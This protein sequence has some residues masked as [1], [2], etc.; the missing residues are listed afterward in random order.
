MGSLLFN[1]TSSTPYPLRLVLN[2]ILPGCNLQIRKVALCSRSNP[3]CDAAFP[4]FQLQIV[5]DE[6]G[7][8]RSMHV[9]PG[10]TAFHLD[11]EPGP[12]AGL[13]IDVRLV[14]FRSFLARPGEIEIRV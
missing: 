6:A 2:S 11:L 5:D 4:W 8:L 10:F 12:D 9:Q 13:E 7:L 3:Q 1:A 14:L